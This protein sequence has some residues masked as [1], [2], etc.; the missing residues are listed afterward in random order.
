[1]D[2]KMTPQECEAFLADVHIGV[3]SVTDEGRGPLSVP[4]WYLYKP[5][6]EILIATSAR[7]RKVKLIEK[8]G[9]FSI[10]VQDENSPYK[11]VSVEGP[12]IGTEPEDLERHERP[13]AHR[14]LGV[15]GG[16][17]YIEATQSTYEGLE[18]VAISMKPERWLS[19]DYS[20]E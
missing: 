5:G 15:E 9:R 20:K 19:V 14:Y 11:Y 1:M 8:A 18:M 7:S 2:L 3:L 10:C 6:G 17:A 16:D 13:L 12:V 4:I